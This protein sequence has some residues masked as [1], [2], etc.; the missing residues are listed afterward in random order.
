VPD[1]VRALAGA[2][3]G[4]PSWEALRRWRS[5]GRALRF[6]LRHAHFR[7]WL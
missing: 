2:G 6:G 3:A 5:S 7:W 1:L 4:V